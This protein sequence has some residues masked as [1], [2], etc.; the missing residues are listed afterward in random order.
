MVKHPYL[1]CEKIIHFWFAI[2]VVLRGIVVFHAGLGFQTVLIGLYPVVRTVQILENV[3]T[4]GIQPI[5]EQVFERRNREPVYVTAII[6]DDVKID[7]RPEAI[8]HKFRGILTSNS[9]LNPVFFELLAPRIDI[10]PANP[11]VSKIGSPG[12]KRRPILYR[13]FQNRYIL[14][15]MLEEI[16]LI[17]IQI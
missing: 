14:I 15:S 17:D 1:V 9:D 7:I 6:N 11:R 16:F 13:N 5:V 12:P 4:A 2:I 10:Y 8:I 3:N